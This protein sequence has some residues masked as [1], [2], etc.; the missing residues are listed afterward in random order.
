MKKSQELSFLSI[1]IL[2]EILFALSFVKLRILKLW[3]SQEK[4]F[5]RFGTLQAL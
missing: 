1:Q 5:F 4:Y 2:Q 3:T